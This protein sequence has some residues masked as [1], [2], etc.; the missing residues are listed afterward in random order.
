MPDVATETRRWPEFNRQR[1]TLLLW[2][3]RGGCWPV[4]LSSSGLQDRW[5]GSGVQVRNMSQGEYTLAG[6]VAADAGCRPIARP[7]PCGCG[8][9]VAL[10]L[11]ACAVPPAGAQAQDNGSSPQRETLSGD[12]GGTRS[13]WEDVGLSISAAYDSESAGNLSGGRYQTARYT[14]QL[15]LGMELDLG[16]LWSIE[17]GKIQVAVADRKGKSLSEDALGNLFPVQSLYGAGLNFRLAELNYQQSLRGGALQFQVGWSP[18]GDNFALNPYACH[19]QN[20]AFCGKPIGLGQDS[21]GARHFPVAQWGGRIRVALAS[22]GYA[23]TGAYLVNP[24][25][26]DHDHGWKLGFGHTGVLVPLELGWA[27]QRGL[28]GLPGQYKL[29]YYRNSADSPDVYRDVNGDPAGLTGAPFATRASRTGYYLMAVQTLWQDT[30]GSVRGFH[31]FAAY[32]K[33]DSNV[34]PFGHAWEIGAVWK[35]PV[36][37]RPRDYLAVAFASAQIN[38]RTTRYQ[39]DRNQVAPGA[40]G[41]QT[42]ERIVELT[43]NLQVAPWLSV[44]PS[45]QYIIRPG[46]TGDIPDA[47]V[48]GLGTHVE[49]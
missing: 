7:R 49:F 31:A 10:L 32:T 1:R 37:R 13:R 9:L 42:Y 25:L 33:G 24:R 22:D 5:S 18:I 47:F 8:G 38:P 39:Q 19:F 26:G 41:T 23:S 21:G 29:G 46:A 44:R 17:G 27:P 34:A 45:L 36:T 43:Y 11:F 28:W 48:V 12:W 4:R 40:G 16:R 30:P 3:P 20:N 15:D 35:G 14:Q 2:L 6:K